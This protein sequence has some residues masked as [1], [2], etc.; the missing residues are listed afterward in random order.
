MDYAYK[1]TTHGRAALAACLAR[2][3]PLPI[4]RVAFGSGLADES[5]ELA[6]MHA[7]LSPVAD[8][9]IADRR[10]EDD[11]LYLTLQYANS[12]H[13]TVPA[14]LLSEFLVFA[15][16]PQTGEE[17][18]FLYGTLG[19]Y[20]QPVPAYHE[21]FPPCVF[22]FPLTLVLSNDL[23]VSVSAPAGLATFDDLSALIGALAVRRMD[24]VI[25]ASGWTAQTGA[26]YP[27]QR[28]IPVASATETMIPFLTVL[29]AGMAAADACGLAPLAQTLKGAVR[30][31]AKCAPAQDIAA[32]LSLAGDA[33]GFC[34]LGGGE[35]YTLP[36][37]TADTLGGVKIGSGVTV[38]NNGT[39][40]VNTVQVAEEAAASDES[41]EEMLDE[42]FQAL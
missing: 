14:F 2:E 27:V 28:D 38:Q 7:L 12:E 6:D 20:R 4:T 39:I 9:T 32:S 26:A 30:V 15:A 24:I 3:R 11:R 25:P 17:T 8:G 16:D 18:D 13:K 35:A 1:L 36:P 41:A 31:F 5:T 21:A 23:E 34:V 40:S 33:S 10:H 22:N 37:A 19:D 29:P 42:I